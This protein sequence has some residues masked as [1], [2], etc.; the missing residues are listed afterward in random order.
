MAGY[1]ARASYTRTLCTQILEYD[2]LLTGSVHHMTI[3]TLEQPGSED[4]LQARPQPHRALM[5][6]PSPSPPPSPLP[7]PPYVCTWGWM[8]AGVGGVAGAGG[9]AAIVG[10][11]AMSW[12]GAG[13]SRFP[14]RPAEAMEWRAAMARVDAWKRVQEERRPQLDASSQRRVAPLGFP[15]G[16]GLATMLPCALRLSCLM[17]A[18]EC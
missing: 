11:G 10:L 3:V 14:L 7:F 4:P 12:G 1:P 9:V 8:V 17:S 16:Q 18:A 2:V 13:V 6:P 5:M 15:G